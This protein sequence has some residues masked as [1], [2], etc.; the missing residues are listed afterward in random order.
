MRLLLFACAQCDAAGVSN[1]SARKMRAIMEYARVPISISQNEAHPFWRNDALVSFCAQNGIHFTAFSPLGSP[2]SAEIF[3]RDAPVLLDDPSIAAIAARHGKNVGQ[4]LI[5]WALQARP[6]SSALP[7]S[8]SKERIVGNAAMAGWEL[9][10]D[11]MR[12]L[13]SF[14]M[15]ARSVHGGLFLTPAGPYRTMADL[16]DD[17]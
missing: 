10:E 6:T 11:A 12:T 9:D 14:A 2:D 8:V 5:R 7:K 16:W 1:F 13:S 15:Q 17:E 4:V 3:R